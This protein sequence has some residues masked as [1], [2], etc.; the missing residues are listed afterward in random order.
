MSELDAAKLEIQML[1]TKVILYEQL[2]EQTLGLKFTTNTMDKEIHIEKFPTGNLKVILTN[3]VKKKKTKKTKKTVK[4]KT[5]KKKPVYRTISNTATVSEVNLEVAFTTINKV[6]HARFELLHKV[7]K[8]WDVDEQLAQ[9]L[10]TITTGGYKASILR[11]IM[12]LRKCCLAKNTLAKYTNIL[13]SHVST[14]Q[15]IY[16]KKGY[17]KTKSDNAIRKYISPI[18]Q[19]LLRWPK[20]QNSYIEGDE[21]EQLNA[22][23]CHSTAFPKTWK[24]FELKIYLENILTYNLALFPIIN[25]LEH[26]MVNRYGFYNICYVDKEKTTDPYMYYIL[27]KCEDIRSWKMDCRLES[28]TT[29]IINESLVYMIG[30]FKEIYRTVYHDNIFRPDFTKTQILEYEGIQLMKNILDITNIKTFNKTIRKMFIQTS[31]LTLATK[32]KFNLYSDDR[33]QK[34]RMSNLKDIPFSD[35]IEHVCKMLFTNGMSNSDIQKLTI[36]LR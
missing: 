28:T 26:C 1:R 23:M 5:V 3:L 30:L 4:K 8:D 17:S 13:N 27:E 25:V 36:L 21:I 20:Y 22:S 32:D 2:L 34:M 18:E 12:S 14:F 11:K 16:K 10:Q 24:P 9:K 19:R 29:D 35:N 7:W 6:D 31:T 33:A 15:G